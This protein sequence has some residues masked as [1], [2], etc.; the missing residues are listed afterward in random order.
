MSRYNERTIYH[1]IKTIVPEASK[2]GF[3]Q[4]AVALNSRFLRWRQIARIPTM[5]WH[6]APPLAAKSAKT[7][8]WFEETGT[9]SM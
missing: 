5:Q 2:G 4:G 7:K 8:K 9:R 1:S 6:E 3:G